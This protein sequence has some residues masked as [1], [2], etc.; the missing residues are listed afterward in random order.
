MPMSG[1]Q[2]FG[3]HS[4]SLRDAALRVWDRRRQIGA[5]GA[6]AALGIYVWV[7][8]SH[9]TYNVGGSD[10]A[11]YLTAARWIA[12]ADLTPR[13]T[14]LDVFEVDDDEA[15]IFQPLGTVGGPDPGT[16]AP[17]YP[18]GVPGHMLGAATLFG[19][20]LGPYLVSPVAA[21]LGLLLVY[22]IGIELGLPRLHAAGATAVLGL[23][24]TYLFIGVQPM[25]DVLATL[26]TMAAVY[27]AVRADRGANWAWLCGLS[28]G[29]SVTVRPA[30]MILLPTLLIAFPPKLGTYLRFIAGGL[31][32]AAAMSTYNTIAYTTPLSTGYSTHLG[33]DMGLEFF[34]SRF[35]HYA[36]WLGRT[37]TWAVPAGWVA[38]M[39]DPRQSW[40]RR[41]ML[42]VWFLS[43]FLF[44]CFYRH[45][46]QWW[47][48]RFLMPA[49]PALILATFLLLHDLTRKQRRAVA[50]AALGVVCLFVLRN[51]V[52]QIEELGALTVW[53]G[54]S[55]YLEAARWVEDQVPEQTVLL[56]MQMSAAVTV[57]T[58]HFVLRWDHLDAKRFR[59][60]RA[61]IEERGYD[62][63][64]LLFNW[65]VDPL[66]ERLP[67]DWHEIGAHRHI[68]LWRLA[69]PR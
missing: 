52:E 7:V 30:N 10:S 12:A 20:A 54:E 14:A 66:M 55:V 51:E 17:Y 47:Y 22:A 63:Y 16:L 58:D 29:I 42:A 19:W 50:I 48:T 18:P 61:R 38:V 65:E 24:P 69:E 56:T 33:T 13:V 59:E 5:I 1:R 68:S 36:F 32:A 15:R 53:E 8:L 49:V 28:F 21:I 23:W 6:V 27:A 25:G 31:P 26:W 45:Y 11:G 34:P 4:E 62:L 40:R 60:L 9:T 35:R 3:T 44:Y 41:A 57:Y 46:D 37:L 39:A 67:G 64:A 43:Y 2:M